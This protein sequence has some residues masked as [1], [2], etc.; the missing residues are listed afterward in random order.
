[1]TLIKFEPLKDL[2]L[3]RSNIRRF[4]DDFPTRD[5]GFV[6]NFHPRIDIL[7]DEKNVYVEA[8]VPG[9][10]KKDLKISVQDNI[11]TISGEKKKAEEK[12]D[13]NYARAERIFGSFTR[14]FTLPEDVNTEKIEAKFE[15]GI[16]KI[17]MEKHSQKPVTEKLIDIK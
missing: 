16:L 9:I 5:Y 11:L 10:N 13:K 12:K 6:D 17:A 3:F 7:E 14:S 1:M 15:D 2:E 4:F 8:E